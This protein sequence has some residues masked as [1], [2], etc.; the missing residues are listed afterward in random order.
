MRWSYIFDHEREFCDD[1]PYQAFTYHQQID[2]ALSYP[3]E[4]GSQFGLEGSA[5]GSDI[6]QPWEGVY[7]PADKIVPMKLHL[8][9]LK[10]R[11]VIYNRRVLYRLSEHELPAARCAVGE[12]WAY[13]FL[14]EERGEIALY[15]QPLVYADDSAADYQRYEDWS[16]REIGH[17]LDGSSLANRLLIIF[18]AMPPMVELD[19]NLD[20]FWPFYSQKILLFAL[21]ERAFNVNTDAFSPSLRDYWGM[22]KNI[23]IQLIRL[24]HQL[25]RRDRIFNL[26]AKRPGISLCRRWP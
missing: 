25:K 20:E 6:T 11:A 14:S 2:M 7:S 18:E 9:F 12:P 8:R 23:G 17:I 10:L 15:P 4:A 1:I 19:T 3:W 22:R 5:R 26:R 24:L 21:L 13:Y 16:E